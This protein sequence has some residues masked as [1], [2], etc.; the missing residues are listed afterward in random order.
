[1]TKCYFSIYFLQEMIVIGPSAHALALVHGEPLPVDG[2]LLDLEDDVAV[3]AYAPDPSRLPPGNH[4]R[5]ADR[6]AGDPLIAMAA[7]PA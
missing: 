4:I 1:M 5:A 7:A 6:A 3:A 2:V